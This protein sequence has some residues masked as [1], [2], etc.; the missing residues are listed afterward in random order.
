M[1][2]PSMVTREAAR[3]ENRQRV[4]RIEAER[5]RWAPEATTTE[6]SPRRSRWWWA[7]FTARSHAGH[8]TAT[9]PT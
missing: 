7:A 3:F 6:G 4:R 5:L 2:T 8:G 1:M 9:V